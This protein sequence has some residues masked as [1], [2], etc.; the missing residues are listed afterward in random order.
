[1]PK[2][3]DTLDEEEFQKCLKKPLVQVMF[4]NYVVPTMPV[5]DFTVLL[6]PSK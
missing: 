1:M 5:F 3:S 6:S 2:R 4:T